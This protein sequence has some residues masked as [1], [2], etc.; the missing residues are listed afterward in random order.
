MMFIVLVFL[1]I[2]LSNKENRGVFQ[3]KNLVFGVASNLVR[4]S[5]ISTH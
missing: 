5:I 2:W 4:F 3:Y 1:E